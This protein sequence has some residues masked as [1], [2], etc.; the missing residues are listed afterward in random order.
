MPARIHS[1]WLNTRNTRIYCVDLSSFDGNPE[2]AAAEMRATREAIE[3]LGPHSLLVSVDLHGTGLNVE[4][5]G[6][7]HG[8]AGPARK[9]A[10][11]GV[12]ALR[13]VW[14][15]LTGLAAWPRQ[16]RFFDDFEKAKDWL[17]DEGF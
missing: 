8:C 17:A 10:L 7:L 9:M 16:A 12:P 1:T 2:G 11:L 15:R 4:I 6:F 5:E 3:G 13:R 14:Y